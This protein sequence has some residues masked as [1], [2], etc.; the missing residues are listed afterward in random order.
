[1]TW[2]DDRGPRWSVVETV[3][4]CISISAASRPPPEP[5]NER[6][7]ASVHDSRGAD[8]ARPLVAIKAVRAPSVALP[9]SAVWDQR[10]LLTDDERRVRCTRTGDDDTPEFGNRRE[11]INDEMFTSNGYRR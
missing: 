5:T 4:A 7:A 8:E 1:M 3:G 9:A 2:Q 10:V 6:L 11:E